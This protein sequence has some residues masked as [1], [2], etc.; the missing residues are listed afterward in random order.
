VASVTGVRN[1]VSTQPVRRPGYA[2]P[3][4]WCPTR[5][6]SSPLLST[7]PASTRPMSSRPVSSRL[8]SAPS[9]RSRPSPPTSSGGVWDQV[10]ATG[11]RHHSNRVEVP[12]AAAPSGGPDRRPRSPGAGGA[13]GV[14]R[15][16][17]GVSVADPGRVGCGWRQPRMP[18]TRP[19]RPGRRAERSWL[20]AAL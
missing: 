1:A 3:A 13:A 2:D 11:N 6:A 7:R 5:P 9:V 20:V 15:W 17:V 14:A 18:T 16:S 12:V 4:G 10:E 8:L 19:G